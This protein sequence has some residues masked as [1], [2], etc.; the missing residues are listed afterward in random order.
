MKTLTFG[1]VAATMALLLTGCTGGD[2]NGSGTSSASSTANN[3]STNP[4]GSAL[5][6]AMVFD[7]G[8]R[9]DKSFN[10]SAYAGLQRAEKEFGFTG[11]TVD[12]KAAK[13]YETNLSTLAEDGNDVIFAIGINQ[14]NAVQAIAPKYPNVHFA[15]V[16]APVDAPNVRSLLFSE[17]QGSYLAGF[18][19]GST[20]KT[21]K[22]GF[23]GGQK[24]DLIEKFE[25]GYK[26]GALAA[27]PKVVVLPGKYTESWDDTQAG[28]ENA[29]ALF[30]DGADI[31]YHA[32]GRCGIGVIEA[33]K[34]T[35]KFA[36]GVDG[37]QDDQAPGHV[38]TSM[39]KH[40]DEAV[41]QTIKDVKDGK[42]TPGIKVYDLKVNGVGLSDMKYTKDIIGADTLKKL[43]QV[44]QDIIDGKIKVPTK[45]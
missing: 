24:I 13:D 39:I 21:G 11:R 26:A 16:D 9:G 40:V 10:D 32:A 7:M 34:E 15:I 44:K 27:N 42:F 23:V 38:L 4:S 18:I 5:K 36:I 14:Q 22:I 20:T 45:L 19:A 29:K 43:D 12:T 37:D 28:K 31:V 33:A 6:V 8:G 1:L 41:Y 17:E 3:G 35:G 30:S 25:A 2:S